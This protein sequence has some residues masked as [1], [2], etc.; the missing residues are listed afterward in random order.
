V[1]SIPS[2]Y[3]KKAGA[4]WWKYVIG[5]HY[6]TNPHNVEQWDN[7]TILETLASLKMLG[8]IK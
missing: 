7:D 8:V 2:S 3:E 5:Y 6:K 1:Q 4:K